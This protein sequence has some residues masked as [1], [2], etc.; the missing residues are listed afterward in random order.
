MKT[1]RE[2]VLA[3]LAAAV[4]AVAL[5]TPV[6]AAEGGKSRA[7]ANEDFYIISSVDA[8]K[9]EIVL[10]RPTEVTELVLVT[11]KTTYWSEDGKPVQFVDLRAGDTIYLVSRRD[12]GGA[13]VAVRIRIS[14]SRCSRTWSRNDS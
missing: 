1:K 8:K 10:K 3:T 2:L 6:W 4:L 12:P 5:L 11:E 14:G 13:R 7:A 9:N